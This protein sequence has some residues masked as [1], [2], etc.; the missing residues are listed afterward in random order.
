MTKE[1]N[2]RKYNLCIFIMLV[3]VL[4][5]MCEISEVMSQQKKL[6]SQKIEVEKIRGDKE[7]YSIAE[8]V[9]YSDLT[10]KQYLKKTRQ[11]NSAY[12]SENKR[13]KH[14]STKLQRKLKALEIKHQKDLRNCVLRKYNIQSD[15]LTQKQKDV[16]DEIAY[17]TASNYSKYGILPSIAVAQAMQETTLGT[18]D[19]SATSAFGYWGVK[20]VSTSSLYRTYNSL[21]EGVL[22]YLSTLNNGR[23]DGALFN[24]NVESSLRAIQKGK[25]CIPSEGYADRVLNCIYTF[26]FTEYDNF[27]IG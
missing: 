7:V 8:E 27:Y 10:V 21:E 23:Y 25:Y 14:K 1:H 26:D 20:D 11:E 24:R 16:A 2:Q 5:L 4:V 19:T 6:E 15:V 17:I 22:S 3:G 9:Y 13:L 18:A 12:A